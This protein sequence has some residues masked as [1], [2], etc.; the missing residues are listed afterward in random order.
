MKEKEGKKLIYSIYSFIFP[1]VTT[2][3]KQRKTLF[4][5]IKNTF[6]VVKKSEEDF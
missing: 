2:T 4:D 5:Y 6:F 3:E 1:P